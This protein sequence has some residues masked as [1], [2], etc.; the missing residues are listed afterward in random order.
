MNPWKPGRRSLVDLSLAF[1]VAAVLAVLNLSINFID[2]LQD[3]FRAYAQYRLTGLLVNM[4]FAW[5]A[6]LLWLSFVRWRRA[7]RKQAELEEIVSSISPDTLLVVTP[8]RTIRMCNASVTRIFG[9]ETGEVIGRKT[10]LLYEDRRAEGATHREIYEILM[11][12]GFHIGQATG[13]SKDG[14]TVPLEIITGHLSGG[15][16]AVLLLRDISDRVRAE[17]DRLRLEARVRQQQKL[18]SLGVL[19][20]GVAHDF[21]NLLT[22]ILGNAEL[23]ARG[24]PPDSE[25]VGL[26]NRIRDAALH[27][28]ELCT[29]MLAYS[30]QAE[31]KV[32]RLDISDLVRRMTRLMGVSMPEHSRVEYD[33]AADLPPVETD[34]VQM[35]QVVMNLMTNAADSLPA[36]GGVVKV[37]TGTRECDE[38]F[39]GRLIIPPA[40][41]PGVYAYIQVAD[42]G[43][44]MDAETQA[45]MFDP[46]FT[47]KFMG[48]GLGLASVLGIVRAH[49][50]GIEV[51]SAPGKGTSFRILLP[52]AA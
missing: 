11:K 51:H 35:Q 42:N 45:R 44:G 23:A 22:V 9:Y 31:F 16:G 43:S 13:R 41:S 49:G 47:T 50:G 24:L 48:R 25:A 20:G 5:L 3:F 46:F 28:A 39:L 8:D 14:R 7:A 21:N 2:S 6:L 12:D 17:E 10:D 4:L 15:D 52:A 18:E 32:Q 33:L 27:A 26:M 19:A 29:Q 38:Q 36:A 34:P 30:G 1:A 40:G 37:A